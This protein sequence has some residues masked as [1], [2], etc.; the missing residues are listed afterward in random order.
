MKAMQGPDG[1]RHG[2]VL[3]FSLATTCLTCRSAIA[4]LP[5]YEPN[6]VAY[7]LKCASELLN[8]YDSFAGWQIKQINDDPAFQALGDVEIA[9]LL[10]RAATPANS[11]DDPHGTE[12]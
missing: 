9:G 10:K 5:E 8:T 7:L 11:S 12:K 3:P 1:N 2:R 6:D 4:E